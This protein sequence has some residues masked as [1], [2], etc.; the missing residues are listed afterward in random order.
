[1]VVPAFN[2]KF[3]TFNGC[4]FIFLRTQP[5]AGRMA[6]QSGK[7]ENA[8]TVKKLQTNLKYIFSLD[9]VLVFFFCLIHHY[10]QG[11]N[12]TNCASTVILLP[13]ITV[14]LFMKQKKKSLLSIIVSW[15]CGVSWHCVVCLNNTETRAWTSFGQWGI[16]SQCQCHAATTISCTHYLMVTS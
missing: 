14:L 8:A 11:I 4:S 2:F 1:M 5:D 13:S 6:S 7:H 9:I 10:L 15:H 12:I 3:F 16:V